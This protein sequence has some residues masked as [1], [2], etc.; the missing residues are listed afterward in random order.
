LTRDEV[1]S[2]FC[3]HN[4]D[5]GS[6]PGAEQH[7]FCALYKAGLLGWLEHDLVDNKRRQRF[8]RPGEGT[9]EP[10]G[11]LPASS[12]YLLHPALSPIVARLNPG[13]A[14]RVHRANVVG[15]GLR[16]RDPG[17]P[18]THVLCVLQADVRGML[19][20]MQEGN[21]G[22]DRQSIVEA[23]TRHAASARSREV[24]EGDHVLITHDDAALLARI[25]RR[26][27]DDVYD[28]PGSPLL[29]IA[30][31]CG[32]VRLQTTNEDTLVIGGEAVAVAARIEPRVAPGQIWCTSEF[33]GELAR[34]HSLC[35][36][37]ALEPPAEEDPDGRHP[38]LFNVR[39]RGSDASDL[40]VRL[41]RVEF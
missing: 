36:A 14:E 4:D 41:F 20:L 9:F 2:L 33:Q 23:V 18:R 3:E 6:V 25:A 31:H 17:E 10:D 12:H 32:V 30:L 27:L 26:I 28:A 11:V 19:G 29:R 34:G 35:R 38:G 16:W 24:N 7:V 37:I 22:P 5:I 1:E 39:K 21:D 13:F 40:W 15:N 8:L